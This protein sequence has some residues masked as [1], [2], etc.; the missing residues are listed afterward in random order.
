MIKQLEKKLK[1]EKTDRNQL[2]HMTGSA[3]QHQHSEKETTE[4]ER[5]RNWKFT[6]FINQKGYMI[7]YLLIHTKGKN[8]KK[9]CIKI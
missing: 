5:K 7:H 2:I 8:K 4:A 3:T 6:L 9:K 1:R